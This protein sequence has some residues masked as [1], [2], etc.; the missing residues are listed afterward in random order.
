MRMRAAMIVGITGIVSAAALATNACAGSSTGS[1]DQGPRAGSEGGPCPGGGASCDVGLVCLSNLCVKPG[2]GGSTTSSS[3]SGSSSGGTGDASADDG[4]FDAAACK[5][6]HPLLDGGLR[7]CVGG[8][9][10]C[11]TDDSCYAKDIAGSCCKGKT[12]CY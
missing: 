2:D 11:E 10:H 5:F 6:K 8:E 3:S 4:G 1:L 9:C 7:Y 12:V